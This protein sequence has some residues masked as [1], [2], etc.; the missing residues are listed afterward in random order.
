[1]HEPLGPHARLERVETRGA[2]VDAVGLAAKTDDAEAERDPEVD[3]FAEL[4]GRDR[5]ERELPAGVATI[6]SVVDAGDHRDAHDRLELEPRAHVVVE[7]DSGDTEPEE[8]EILV[9]RCAETERRF[10]ADAEAPCVVF[11][12]RRAA[13]ERPE[14]Q[15]RDERARERTCPHEILLAMTVGSLGGTGP[16]FGSRL[17]SLDSCGR[18]GRD[19]RTGA[20]ST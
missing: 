5:A 1:M 15:R 20:K 10:D 3:L 16:V 4:K 13:E 7:R 11:R 8:H 18:G 9:E 6:G 2:G 12:L 17:T 14:R 19:A